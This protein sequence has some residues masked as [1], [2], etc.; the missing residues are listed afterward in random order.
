MVHALLGHA[1]LSLT[2]ALEKL[3]LQLTQSPFKLVLLETFV[4]FLETHCHWQ[5][6]RQSQMDLLQLLLLVLKMEMLQ[7]HMFQKDYQEIDALKILIVKLL[8]LHARVM[9]AETHSPSKMQLAT[10]IQIV[11]S[12]STAM[13]KNALLSLLLELLAQ[14]PLNNLMP[15]ADLD[16]IVSTLFALHCILNP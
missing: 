7:H 10:H 6:S 16:L 4:R 15:N 1:D 5:V 3:P 13:P 12:D 2:L 9:P 11:M 14:L 8:D